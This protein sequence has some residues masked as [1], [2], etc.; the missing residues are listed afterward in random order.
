[1]PVPAQYP[2]VPDLAPDVS[3]VF[4]STLRRASG[5]PTLTLPYW[6]EG[7]NGKLPTIFRDRTYV[8]ENG[9]T[10]ANPLRVEARRATLNAGTA[11]LA[12]TTTSPANA[13]KA[14][15]FANFSTRMEATPHGS[16]HCAIADGGC[17]NGLMGAVPVAALDP[18][19]YFHHAN[20]DRLYECWLKVDETNRLPTDQT[21]LDQRFSFMQADGTAV[22][23]SQVRD[24]LTTAQLGYS[25]TE[26]SGC[27]TYA[28]SAPLAA[29]T[30]TT[31]IARAAQATLTAAA[32]AAPMGSMVMSDATELKR[33]TTE[34]PIAIE[35]AP[36]ARAAAPNARSGAAAA[37]TKSAT[38]T[39]EGVNAAVVPGVLYN[40][41]LAN[42]AGKRQQV[43]VINFFGFG[44]PAPTGK[45][46]H[47]MGGRTFEFDATDAVRKLGLTG[48]RKPKLIFEPTTGLTDS[49]L[50]QA[51]KAIP[52]NAKVSFTSASLSV[53]P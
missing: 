3:L 43:G 51:T 34:L 37:A 21:I 30:A 39:I 22:R 28:S 49:T 31:E 47:D 12:A 36:A 9:K 40:V 53:Q 11:K 20:I 48:S 42:D 23:E 4:E 8:N 35:T 26:G 6:D 29:A 52:A 18:I 46:A 1:M 5:D 32:Q 38:L 14:T 41:F 15:T 33:G 17:P 45:H 16:V 44:G 27:P 25:Y 24:M 19:F 13:M 10:V 7:A 2:A 50:A